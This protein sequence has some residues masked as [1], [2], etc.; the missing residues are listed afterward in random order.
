MSAPL[1]NKRNFDYDD[2]S[3]FDLLRIGSRVIDADGDYWMR[4][5]RGWVCTS[6]DIDHPY[7]SVEL[8]N[9]F[10]PV[11]RVAALPARSATKRTPTC[12]P[13]PRDLPGEPGGA[14][15]TSESD[16]FELAARAQEEVTT[17]AGGWS[18]VEC[19]A[20]A[21]AAIAA[22]WRPPAKVITTVGE[23]AA[24]PNRT[25]VLSEQGG[26]W[27]AEDPFGTTARRWVEPGLTSIHPSTHIA[28]PATVI[29][30]P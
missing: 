14:Q 10:G 23:L 20:I 29:W 9:E 5:E 2:H 19:R 30:E 4:T 1:T 21:K 16:L 27:I 12:D 7:T 15:T 3:E 11:R 25:V 8:L 28:L 26:T 13:N 6:D 18:A 17:N 24:V 22:G